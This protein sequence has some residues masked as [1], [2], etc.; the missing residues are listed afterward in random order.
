MNE[1]KGTFGL[2][3]GQDVDKA[4]SR[5]HAVNYVIA[6]AQL[7]GAIDYELKLILFPSF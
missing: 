4:I 2:L 7:E 5:V 6:T 3:D 1:S